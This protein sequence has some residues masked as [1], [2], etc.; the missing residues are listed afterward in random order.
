M[1]TEIWYFML[2]AELLCELIKPEVAC[3]VRYIIVQ[4]QINSSGR[5]ALWD[6]WL[7]VIYTMP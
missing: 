5:R 6:D 1:V 7:V 4:Y 2:L 3:F